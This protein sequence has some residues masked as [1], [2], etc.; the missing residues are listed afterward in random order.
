MSNRKIKK[1]GA[2]KGNQ[3]ARKHGFY[4]KTL[5]PWQQDMVSSAV[6]ASLDRQIAIARSRIASV[7]ANDPKNIR[8]LTAAVTSLARLLRHNQGPG[9]SS[10]RVADEVARI[11]SFLTT[12]DN[13]A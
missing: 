9:N 1:V 7:V 6:D 13:R 8:I 12:Q 2:P 4:S 3:N 10:L 5:A 11:V